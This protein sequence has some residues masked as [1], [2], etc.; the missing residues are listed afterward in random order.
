MSFHI[1]KCLKRTKIKP[2]NVDNEFRKT[3]TPIKWFFSFLFQKRMIII[4]T[5]KKYSSRKSVYRDIAR[6]LAQGHPAAP[7]MGKWLLA[8]RLTRNGRSNH[9]LRLRIPFKI[10]FIPENSRVISSSVAWVRSHFW[11]TSCVT[12]SRLLCNIS[13]FV[14][15]VCFFAVY[16]Y[17]DTKK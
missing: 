13:V 17:L 14:S 11:M 10:K 6:Q 15:F 3:N 9:Q 16:L 1:V 2:W 5:T 12:V 4:A 8:Y 7:I